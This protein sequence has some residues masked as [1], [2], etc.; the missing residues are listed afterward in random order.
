MTVS[1]EALAM[2]GMDY[3]EWGMDVQEWERE[4]PPPAY[5]LAEEEEG[6]GEGD[7]EPPPAYLLEEEEGE[8][9][10]EE[11][12]WNLS[13]ACKP[14]Q[15]QNGDICEMGTDLHVEA[16]YLKL[17]R[18]I[19]CLGGENYYSFLVHYKKLS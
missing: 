2:A 6:E 16:K 18:I 14:L 17:W 5:L 12:T 15:N 11:V 3:L 1:I 13:S 10:E 19:Y 7:E 9:R 8:E 4:E